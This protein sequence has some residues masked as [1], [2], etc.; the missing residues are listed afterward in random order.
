MKQYIQYFI[1]KVVGDILD[2]DLDCLSVAIWSGKV[3]LKNISL[4]VENIVDINYLKVYHGAVQNVNIYIPWSSILKNPIEI[5]VDGVFLD[6]GPVSYSDLSTEEVLKKLFSEK[7]RQLFAYENYLD[8]PSSEDEKDLRIDIIERLFKTISTKIVMKVNNVHIRFE[9][10][11]LL[12]SSTIASGIILSSFVIE[13]DNKISEDDK[14]QLIKNITLSGFGFYWDY[15]TVSIC[16]LPFKVWQEKM[17]E[18]IDYENNEAYKS[19]FIIV[20]QECNMDITVKVNPFSKSEILN[21]IDFVCPKIKINIDS[22]QLEQIYFLYQY[23]KSV[24]NLISTNS[25]RPLKRPTDGISAR[26]WWKYASKLATL[27][28]SYLKILKKIYIS[29][30]EKKSY[31]L[32]NDEQNLLHYCDMNIPIDILKYFRR[33]L[34]EEIELEKSIKNKAKSSSWWNWG[35][36][37]I[38]NSILDLIINFKRIDEVNHFRVL[39]GIL[40]N[41]KLDFIGFLDLSI[42]CQNISIYD[43]YIN[44]GATII[45]K[46]LKT[47]I[48]CSINDIKIEESKDLSLSKCSILS[49]M[50]NS[51]KVGK[52]LNEED[53]DKI[54]SIDI[55]HESPGPFLVNVRAKQV[56]IYLNYLPLQYLMSEFALTD[57]REK[58]SSI[59]S[60]LF[61]RIEHTLFYQ[62][63][64]A[65]SQYT[66]Q[67]AKEIVNG[68]VASVEIVVEAYAPK[69]I[70]PDPLLN[71]KYI[72]LDCGFVKSKCEIIDG[73][74]KNELYVKDINIY[75]VDDLIK[76]EISQENYIINPFNVEI[77]CQNVV[78][79]LAD[80]T[81]NVIVMPYMKGEVNLN[82]MASSLRVLLNVSSIFTSR[83][84]PWCKKRSIPNQIWV[85]RYKFIY[86]IR[87]KKKQQ[88]LGI[89]DYHDYIKYSNTSVNSFLRIGLYLPIF[90]I[91]LYISDK[92]K[93]IIKSEEVKM[94][95]IIR[96]NDK[97]I[98]LLVKKFFIFYSYLVTNIEND[99]TMDDIFEKEI[100][101]T[102]LWLPEEDNKEIKL[103]CLIVDNK[104][105]PCYNNNFIDLK[106]RIKK[107]CLNLD[108]Y[109]LNKLRPF[110]NVVFFQSRL[111]NGT[112][113]NY[114]D[115][116]LRQIEKKLKYET[117]K[118]LES[119]S[120]VTNENNLKEEKEDLINEKIEGLSIEMNIDEIELNLVDYNEYKYKDIKFFTIKIASFSSSLNIKGEYVKGKIDIDDIDIIDLRYP[121]KKQNIKILEGK[122]DVQSDKKL[123]EIIA[124]FSKN[125]GT[126]I[127]LLVNKIT[128]F[129][130]YDGLIDFASIGFEILM[131]SLS[132]FI[133]N[134]S[135]SFQEVYLT[136][137]SS[138]PIITLSISLSLIDSS[139]VIL[140]DPTSLVGSSGALV[141]NGNTFLEYIN[142][143]HPI[144]RTS[145]E[146]ITIKCYDLTSYIIYNLSL[147]LSKVSSSVSNSFI[148]PFSVNI[149]LKYIKP[150]NEMNSIFV[151]FEIDEIVSKISFS[152][153]LI[154]SSILNRR[155]LSKKKI[156]KIQFSK[157]A[158]IRP[159][160]T[161]SLVDKSKSY[162]FPSKVEIRMNLSEISF[163]LIHDYANDSFPVIKFSSDKTLLLLEGSEDKLSGEVNCN[164]ALDF[165]NTSMLEW[166]SLIE[167][168]SPIIKLQIDNENIFF[169]LIS[170]KTIQINIS[171]EMMKSILRSSS[172]LFHKKDDK[173]EITKNNNNDLNKI[174]IKNCLGD[175]FKV[176]IKDSITSELL[177]N[178]STTSNKD[179][180]YSVNSK[181][182]CI[183][184]Q[185][186]YKDK[187]YVIKQVNVLS[188]EPIPFTLLSKFIKKDKNKITQD[189]NEEKKNDII[190]EE[191]DNYY[192][193][194]L[195]ENI[196]SKEEEIYEYQRFEVFSRKWKPPF[197]PND[198]PNFSDYDM[199]E[200]L[201]FDSIRID[202]KKWK[203]VGPWQ[204]DRDGVSLGL[205]DEDGWHYGKSFNKLSTLLIPF[206]SSLAS[207]EKN[208][209]TS[210]TVRRRRWRRL[211]VSIESI[212]TS[213]PIIVWDL[214]REQYGKKVAL[215]RSSLLI[216]NSLRISLSILFYHPSWK[217]EVVLGPIDPGET[218][219][220][221]LIYSK[222][223]SIRIRPSKLSSKW[224]N[225]LF[226][227][228]SIYEE[229]TTYNI[230]C[231][232]ENQESYLLNFRANLKRKSRA[233]E[234]N[235]IPI[236]EIKNL[237]MCSLQYRILD[238]H[239]IKS[240][241]TG[242]I[243]SG[244][245]THSL[246]VTFDMKPKIS[247]QIGSYEWSEPIKLDD[248]KK[249]SA[250][251]F[252]KPT[253]YSSNCNINDNPNLIS[254]D[255][256]ILHKEEDKL[257]RLPI[258][259]EINA[260]EYG[261]LI[262]EIYFQTLIVNLSN[263]PLSIMG[264]LKN[265]NRYIREVT[266]DFDLMNFA[267]RKLN[268][269][270]KENLKKEQKKSV[271]IEE[272]DENNEEQIKN[273]NA[274]QSINSN[275]SHGYHLL[276]CNVGEKVYADDEYR[277]YHVPNYLKKHEAVTFSILEKSISDNEEKELIELNLKKSSIVFIL[278]CSKEI[279]QWIIDEKYFNTNDIAVAKKVVYKKKYN[280]DDNVQNYLDNNNDN[281]TSD[282]YN[283]KYYE[284]I[285]KEKTYSI[286]G[287]K[288]S[289]NEKIVI[290]KNELNSNDLY[291]IAIVS[292]LFSHSS[293]DQNDSSTSD[294]IINH[295]IFSEYFD[296][297]FSGLCWTEGYQN[298]TAFYSEDYSLKIKKNDN[299][300]WTNEIIAN[301]NR[302][303]QAEGDIDVRDSIVKKI[304]LLK[305]KLGI[306]PG[307]FKKT[308]IITI[309]PRYCIL[310]CINTNI[311]VKQEN[312]YEENILEV[313]P[314]EPTEWHIL[315]K[316]STFLSSIK[317]KKIIL[318]N[319]IGFNSNLL[320]F[321]V[322]T[323]ETD[324][325]YCPIDFNKFGSIC[326]FLP[327]LRND[328]SDKYSKK[329][330]VL[331]IEVR[332]SDPSDNC[333]VVAIIWEEEIVNKADLSFQNLTNLPICIRQT[334]FPSHKT[335]THKIVYNPYEFYIKPFSSCIFGWV[336]LR[337]EKQIE[338]S[339]DGNFNHKSL[340]C[341]LDLTKINEK[342]VIKLQKY[343][344]EQIRNEKVEFSIYTINYGLVVCAKFINKNESIPRSIS[345]I[346]NFNFIIQF[347]I[348]LAS[349]G[350]SLIVENPIRREL[351]SFFI[352]TF[353]M[354][355]N[356]NDNKTK[357]DIY[358][359][360]FQLDNYSET[361]V[362]PVIL[363]STFKDI[364]S[365]FNSSQSKLLGYSLYDGVYQNFLSDENNRPTFSFKLEV[366]TNE[367]DTTIINHFE[368]AIEPLTIEIDTVTIQL[369][370]L[371]FFN[372]LSR[373][374]K[375]ELLAE[376]RPKEWLVK[377]NSIALNS[378]IKLV[379]IYK[380][381]LKIQQKK[382]YIN[383]LIINP[384][385]VTFTLYQ[386]TLPRY[387][388]VNKNFEKE[389]NN[390]IQLLLL[391]AIIPFI[392]LDKAPIKLEGI[393]VSKRQESPETILTLLIQKSIQDISLQLPQIAGSLSFFG[394][395]T[396]M[397]RK[398]GI[399][400]KAFILEPYKGSKVGMTEFLK[401]GYNGLMILIREGL[402]GTMDFT[403][404]LT[405]SL[406]KNMSYLTGDMKYVKE[407]AINEQVN[408]AKSYNLSSGI[409]VGS[410]SILT[411]ISTGISGL[412]TK[413]IEYS[414]DGGFGV[415][416]GIGMG[417]LGAGIKPL[418]GVTEGLTSITRSFSRFI[419]VANPPT[420]IRP[421]RA[422]EHIDEEHLNSGIIIP[423]NIEANY[424]QDLI[425]SRGK[426]FHY[427]DYLKNYIK[428][429]YKNGAVILSEMYILWKKNNKKYFGVT[430]SSVS[431][432]YC[433]D[434]K[435]KLF[436]YNNWTDYFIEKDIK[437]SYNEFINQEK[438]Y[439]EEDTNP[440][441]GYDESEDMIDYYNNYIFI[442]C[443]SKSKA[444]YVYNLLYLNGSKMGNPSL[445]VPPIT[446]EDK[447]KSKKFIGNIEKDSEEKEIENVKKNEKVIEI[448]ENEEEKVD[449]CEEIDRNLIEQEIEAEENKILLKLNQVSVGKLD[450]YVF[451][452][453]KNVLNKEIQG[454]I[455]KKLHKFYREEKM[456]YNLTIKENKENINKA[457]KIKKDLILI[458][459]NYIEKNGIINWKELDELI[460]FLL[461][462][463][464]N[465]NYNKL[466][467][468]FFF[469]P[470]TSNSR[471]S[472][473]QKLSDSSTRS[474]NSF[475]FVCVIIN[476]S[477]T[478]MQFNKIIIRKRKKLT[479][480]GSSQTNYDEQKKI[481]YPFGFIVLIKKSKKKHK[482]KI[483]KKL[484]TNTKIKKS[485]K[486]IKENTF[487][488]SSISYSS[489]EIIHFKLY[490]NLFNFTLS[491]NENNLIV[492]TKQPGY[493]ANFL[494]KSSNKNYF[495]CV[496]VANQT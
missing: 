424:A 421:I 254:K 496:I 367:N 481:L 387:H 106:I 466:F 369:L 435:V 256:I 165:F 493:F 245:V 10:S 401:G 345:S 70:L 384:L 423:M 287:K 187:H 219:Y 343:K 130:S 273:S 45:Q 478:P 86:E 260:N 422:L 25:I 229:D 391:N 35:S 288:F 182:K 270:L 218:F 393:S 243:L 158:D 370:I 335:D 98:V 83:K 396:G 348:H 140:E 135:D 305:Y 2:I 380:A 109:T 452:S 128:V 78:K 334:G 276:L 90:S 114:M 398:F 436:L 221:P 22:I 317:S 366:E 336:D 359:S 278:T 468:P 167:P 295:L 404:T 116:L 73:S 237:L 186:S 179:Y 100:E 274:I 58:T 473:S 136:S 118:N 433:I 21:Y 84:P 214:K 204:I 434:T 13:N 164:L 265:N 159:N 249:E 23:I 267:S 94:D 298:V 416:K 32:T 178:F 157:N 464:I 264:K 76:K 443:G 439:E 363:K 40:N 413:P 275:L 63:A 446:P 202:E 173:E 292:D 174:L 489:Q 231:L 151:N 477:Q 277:W 103:S 407:R 289:S 8:L 320:Y 388:T 319:K 329:G 75:I 223:T 181:S 246:H 451:G 437:K 357:I 492:E 440:N 222:A 286:Y 378:E 149:S 491:T 241:E 6:F 110:V 271:N 88:E 403:S 141:C 189:N 147:N 386:T 438:I 129:I 325:S 480:I 432:C 394:S 195:V 284:K 238:S 11:S 108:S 31:S 227:Y 385:N 324:W 121:S 306:L 143:I 64:L 301:I 272:I 192:D 208:N 322:K 358:L 397:F 96:L 161:E 51:Y 406:S 43:C 180:L 236:I 333:S 442:E 74:Y 177:H 188:K 175:E 203:W 72:V 457:K 410:K 155:R 463:K 154:I 36:K 402:S 209:K 450:N 340:T 495:K 291:Y 307:I 15:D 89:K 399:G 315:D 312:S 230:T 471:Y 316:K 327:Y 95:L 248:K 39:K 476:R 97:N 458:L 261:I 487:T 427:Y 494:E 351:L 67:L 133:E 7:L 50:Q 183:D 414:S 483:I 323:S 400:L 26:R 42:L 81:I 479:I 263:V 24:E 62:I 337:K 37:N 225:S 365:K 68:K 139:L 207:S 262:V 82:T 364:K 242:M 87:N 194:L 210:K 80:N 280:N 105:S 12:E 448:S 56:Q 38:S 330:I 352:D 91:N 117:N 356:Y 354:E 224:S 429:D 382:V 134:K 411:G 200:K 123:I 302:A 85:K 412:I 102:I 234:L 152:N 144:D 253:S 52:D 290:K 376:Y 299:E 153:L 269:K 29:K 294:N 79:S 112:D 60:T 326:L 459:K 314:F 156:P 379:N 111:K 168:C 172:V 47:T 441:E 485:T 1:L 191:E 465:K 199:N 228:S 142:E 360:D 18:I 115:E 472:Q 486:K 331:H 49:V 247:F 484:Q 426:K 184:L 55:T 16:N 258:I 65:G 428:L 444:R 185:I 27:K 303:S 355:L 201:S 430:W 309:I 341:Q 338:I 232:L 48:N 321:K 482:K 255:V 467:S 304:Y 132:L 350:I 160:D 14:D 193:L 120:D 77:S 107:V 389:K 425:V 377:F 462:Y 163:T 420:R 213:Q 104:L 71:D 285:V 383:K 328:F 461:N 69:I 454:E 449:V 418:V 390:N 122:K 119:V 347:Y 456:K 125:K 368:I 257:H 148:N 419:E 169:E 233:I 431:H 198:P 170:D 251:M 244:N 392:G 41:F 353:E 205:C 124:E 415:V 266:K 268:L 475:H 93:F 313:E 226:C 308:N 190:N 57:V 342:Q 395:P 211:K 332:L 4:R 371:D 176:K 346:K 171:G 469:L 311:F 349:I 408:L 373:V 293:F 212:F 33:E 127:N 206:T 5:L 197:F 53:E 101:K 162:S 470:L 146:T 417:L 445:L 339:I 131:S 30:N 216:I 34:R 54:I 300:K 447:K 344:N 145:I 252:N 374:D 239:S 362:Y 17:M 296:D 409:K 150:I 215:I 44:F 474:T 381:R 282:Q 9:D 375:A 137:L 490:S 279:P 488:T 138:A 113:K 20:P 196:D 166:E 99:D 250:Y 455:E 28:A 283:E 297:E 126:I 235:F 460:I 281:T 318:P 240:R 310:N 92:E 405:G 61:E 3:S 220:V 217:K 453:N 259:I 46:D 59:N 19:K 361:A 66:S 372:D